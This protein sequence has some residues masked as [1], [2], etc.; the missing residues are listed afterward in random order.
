MD[1]PCPSVLL[2]YEHCFH[3]GFISMEICLSWFEKE[4]CDFCLHMSNTSF[5]LLNEQHYS[6]PYV[7]MSTHGLASKGSALFNPKSVITWWY[8][9]YEPNPNLYVGSQELDW[10]FVG[11]RRLSMISTNDID[12]KLIDKHKWMEERVIKIWDFHKPFTWIVSCD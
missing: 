3:L 1:D 12:H 4:V 8:L 11:N 9:T 10:M 7:A 6:V 5:H 2:S